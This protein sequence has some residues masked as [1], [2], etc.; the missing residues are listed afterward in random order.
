[1]SLHDQY[2]SRCDVFGHEEDSE[3]CHDY[4]NHHELPFKERMFEM[5]GKIFKLADPTPI[6]FDDDGNEH[7]LPPGTYIRLISYTPD[8]PGMRA[9]N[10]WTI[11]TLDGKLSA[12]QIYQDELEELNA[13]D[14]LALI[15]EDRR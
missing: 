8:T 7:D 10:Y 4:W 9:G 1:M 14:R 6:L 15:D 11:Q 12:T 3:D 13:L 5:V 2:C